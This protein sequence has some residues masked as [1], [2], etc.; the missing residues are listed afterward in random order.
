MFC[1]T[2]QEWPAGSLD[3]AMHEALE[4]D[5][6]DFVKL[7]L[8]NGVN[9][10]KCLTISRLESLYNS[11]SKSIILILKKIFKKVIFLAYFLL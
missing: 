3:Q 7:F 8:E 1:V 4:H 11:V 5:R 6:V 9:M 10:N 2:G